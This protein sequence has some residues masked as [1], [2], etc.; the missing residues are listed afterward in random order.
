VK[1]TPLAGVSMRYSFDEGDAPTR[2]ETRYYEMLSTRGIWQKGWKGATEHGPM[3]DKGKFDKDRWLL[4]HT[5]VDHSG[6]RISPTSIL[7]GRRSLP[8]CG[9]RRRGGTTCCR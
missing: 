1:R 8:H 4:F 5:D 9:C 7:T 3:I 2:K 6:R